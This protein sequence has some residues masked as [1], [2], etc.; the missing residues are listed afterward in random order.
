MYKDD[1][2]PAIVSEELWDRAHTLLTA[3]SKR[4]KESGATTHNRYAYSGKIVCAEHGTSFLRAMRGSG[5][6]VWLCRVYNERG[7]KACTAP[8]IYTAEIDAIMADIFL[9]M[10]QDRE[11]IINDIITLIK[12]STDRMNYE[13]GMESLREEIMALHSKK[14]KLLELAVDGAVGNAEFKR[15]NDELNEKLSGLE[16]NLKSMESKRKKSGEAQS[17]INEIRRALERELSME[18]GVNSE[19]VASILEKIVVFNTGDKL[20]IKLQI[21]LAV[22]DIIDREYSRNSLTVCSSI[23]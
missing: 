15:R 21:R 22:G 7:A 13:R 10:R 23:P 9:N 2:I 19:L 3:R 5:K 17:N 4:F 12:S 8:T 20:R 14:E 18:N 1:S 6:E 16:S 11:K